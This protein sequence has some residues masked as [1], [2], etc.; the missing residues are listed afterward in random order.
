MDV[1]FTIVSRNYAAQAASLMESLATAEPKAQRVVVTTDGPIAFADAKIRVIDA[2]TLVPDYAAMC[3]YY[4]AL[5]LNTAVKPHAF[6]ALLG[7]AGVTAGA[8]LDPDI[9]VYRPLDE[10]REG[11]ARAP[12]ALT[13]HLTRPLRG[14]ANPNDH[15]ILTSGAYNLGFM[16]ARAEPQI[17]ALLAWWAEKCRFDCRVDFANGLFTDQKW[18]D[19]APGFVSDLAL[20]RTPALNLAYWNLEGR[21][22]VRDAGGWVVDGEPLGFFHFSG[23][24]PAHPALL[25]KHQDRVKVATGSPLAKLLADY[26]GVLARNGH[27]QA[28][29]TPYGHRAFPSGQIATT[30]QRRRLLAAA[31]RGEDFGGGLTARAEAWLSVEP[32]NVVREAACPSDGPWL[33]GSGELARWLMAGPEAPA[34]EALLRAR[35]DLRDRFATDP[36]GLKA[37]LLGPEALEGRF[38]ARLV[39][40]ETWRDAD[41]P[42]RAAGYVAG[43]TT[44]ARLNFAAYGLALRA[45]WPDALAAALRRRFDAPVPELARGLPFIRL[46]LEIWESRS[47]LQKLFP[48]LSFAQRFA[49]LRWLIGGGLADVGI[50]LSALPA[51]VDSHPVWE[52][53]RLTVRCEPPPHVRPLA[54]GRIGELVVVETWSAG[55]AGRD[56][57]VFD[58]AGGRFRTPGGVPAAPPA[59]VDQVVYKV[60]PDLIPADAVALLANGV[61]WRRAV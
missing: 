11:L 19:L 5:E 28:S 7:E 16:A 31:R 56:A 42:L 59:Q 37:W 26:A 3:A 33:A 58:A 55:C 24:D 1:I 49:F 44:P 13:P 29:Q 60:H 14:E 21:D 30:T 18:M 54:T 32:G 50:D 15:V 53:A 46:F 35:K 61:T 38:S 36:E 9:W 40:A 47:D 22:L 12:L 51:S 39:P 43:D 20:L 57:L 17:D 4:D 45:G 41:L 8:Y 10:V 6:R 52:L 2:A 23:F 48:L 34:I 27:E 25:S